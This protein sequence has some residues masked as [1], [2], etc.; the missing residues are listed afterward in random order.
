MLILLATLEA[1]I[2]FSST[3]GI[4]TNLI[5]TGVQIFIRASCQKKCMSL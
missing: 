2:N 3:K 5:K 1:L 4:V